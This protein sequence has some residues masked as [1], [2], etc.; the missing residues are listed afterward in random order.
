MQFV[1]VVAVDRFICK[2]GKVVIFSSSLGL[3]SDYLKTRS[4]YGL[5][6]FFLCWSFPYIYGHE[7]LRSSF[8]VGKYQIMGCHHLK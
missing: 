7:I 2:L 3:A 4:Q 6:N 1:T 5:S 8:F